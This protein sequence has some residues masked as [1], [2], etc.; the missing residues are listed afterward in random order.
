MEVAASKV[1]SGNGRAVA[2]ALT[3]PTRPAPLRSLQRRW[4]RA[5]MAS[6]TSRPVTCPDGPTVWAISAVSRPGPE[7][8]SSTRSPGRSP[9]A[10]RVAC[11]CSTTSGV[12]QAASSLREAVSSNTDSA[13]IGGFLSRVGSRV[14]VGDS[15]WLVGL[16]VLALVGLEHDH[17]ASGRP[18]ADQGLQGFV[19]GAVGAMD[20]LDDHLAMA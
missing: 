5:S 6:L 10:R 19:L 18:D 4:L 15:G 14:G 13:V 16:A 2:S 7:P 3:K 8:T 12:R 17:V 1:A 20:D 9:S 11:R